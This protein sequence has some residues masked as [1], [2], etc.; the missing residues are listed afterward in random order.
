MEQVD[1]HTV[2]AQLSEAAVAGS[3]HLE[4]GE[5]HKDTS[6]DSQNRLG[7]LGAALGTGAADAD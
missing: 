5:V 4:L 6:L 7:N 1:W 3:F 2:E